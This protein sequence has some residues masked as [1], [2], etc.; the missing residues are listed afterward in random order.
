MDINGEL[1]ASSRC[2]Q[3]WTATCK[4]MKLDCCLTSYTKV[5][6]KWVKDLNVSHETIK[7]LEE[8]IGKNL[9]NEQ[10]LPEHSSSD[11]GNKSKN[12]LMGLHQTKKFLYSKGHHQQ[13]KRHPTVWENLFVNDISDKQLTS[14]IYKNLTHLN[15]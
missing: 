3:N 5:N 9:L 4:R 8:N 10:L 6:S 2:W 15:T 12:E 1:T 13:N 7:L 14:K 11:K